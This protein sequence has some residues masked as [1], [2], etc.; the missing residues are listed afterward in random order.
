[1][2]SPGQE[3]EFLALPPPLRPLT[4]KFSQFSPGLLQHGWIPKW[5]LTK[6]AKRIANKW[7]LEILFRDFQKQKEYNSPW[8]F[9][10]RW[11][12][13]MQR[14]LSSQR[15]CVYVWVCILNMCVHVHVGA[16]VCGGY[17]HTCVCKC[18]WS[19][20]GNLRCHSPGAFHILLEKGPLFCLEC[21]QV[22]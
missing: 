5:S 11:A 17:L 20:E 15:L 18:M 12:S 14:Y 2:S 9:M 7:L 8:V 10:I 19:S 13:K 3:I 21:C 4:E 6:V 1:M 22:G 16:F